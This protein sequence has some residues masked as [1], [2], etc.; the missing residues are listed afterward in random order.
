M[1]SFGLLYQ[2]YTECCFSIVTTSVAISRGRTD[3]KACL[4]QEW[5]A[6]KHLPKTILGAAEKPNM[7][8]PAPVFLT[9]RMSHF[10]SMKLCQHKHHP[11]V[12]KFDLKVMKCTGSNLMWRPEFYYY[13]Y[14]YDLVIN[15]ILGGWGSAGCLFSFEHV[16]FVRFYSWVQW[17]CTLWAMVPQR[18]SSS[19]WGSCRNSKSGGC[20]GRAHSVP[21]GTNNEISA[22]FKAC[23]AFRVVS[24]DPF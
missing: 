16:W 18:V 2:N 15:F 4:R 13:Y 19:T 12:W 24:E 10:S 1:S 17:A 8:C 9:S 6:T 11:V 14:Y 20:G 23:S 5:F 22:L 3:L 7:S 21:P